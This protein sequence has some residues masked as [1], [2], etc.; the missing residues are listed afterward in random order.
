MDL[1]TNKENISMIIVNDMPEQIDASLMQ[2]L[3]KV[4][5]ATVGHFR[6]GIFMPPDFRPVLAETSAVGTAVTLS[7]PGMDS[8]LLHYTMGL[9]RPG[10]VLVIDRGNDHVNA[11]YGGFMA[12][13]AQVVGLAGVVIDG[14]ATDPA[15]LRR[16]G[17]PVWCRGISPV[18]TRIGGDSGMLNV[19]IDC[20]GV[21]VNPGDAVIADE[22]GVLVLPP[23]EVENVA[24][25]ALE[26]Q[27]EEVKEL[28][29]LRQ[30]RSAPELTGAN[31]IIQALLSS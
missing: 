22:S 9:V 3:A 20:G 28:R 2:R 26:M 30:G 25:M 21:V 23:G 8:T 29:L 11:C 24:K 10:D 4:E 7:L 19:T 16:S 12:T 5:T 17:V 15:E 6:S 18:T 1:G 14:T 31:T 27:A 13:A